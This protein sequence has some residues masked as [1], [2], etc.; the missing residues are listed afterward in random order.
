MVASNQVN[1][2]SVQLM[3]SSKKLPLNDYSSIL[4]ITLCVGTTMMWHCWS[5]TGHWNTTAEWDLY[6]SQT[7]TLHLVPC[8]ISL[9]GELLV[10]VPR[11]IQRYFYTRSKDVSWKPWDR[12]IW[13]RCFH[14]ENASNVFHLRTT[15]EKFENPTI[16]G[17]F[18]FV[19]EESSGREITWSSRRHHF[20]KALFSKWFPSA[21]KTQSG[22][23]QILPVWRVFSK[24]LVNFVTD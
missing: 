10:T 15:R 4:A 20:L 19:F 23:F 17:H 13:K 22:R 14:S 7:R 12:K 24:S 21:L 8:A 5:W 9:A 6:V 1:T 3:S 16:S 18:A 11:A 2:I